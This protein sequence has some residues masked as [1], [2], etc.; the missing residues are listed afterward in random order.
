MKK[1]RIGFYERNGFF[2]NEYPYVQPPISQGRKPVPLMI[3][4]SGAAIS[5]KEFEEIRN[6]LYKEVYKIKGS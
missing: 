5:E 6:T 2:L 3:M 1:R 4:T